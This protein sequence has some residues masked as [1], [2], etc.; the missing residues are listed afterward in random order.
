MSL[1]LNVLFALIFLV[2]G[3]GAA[4][5]FY[6]NRSY[7]IVTREPAGRVEVTFIVVSIS[8]FTHAAIAALVLTLDLQSTL[9]ID[10]YASL[11]AMRQGAIDPEA[12]LGILGYGVAATIAACFLGAAVTP[13]DTLSLSALRI[14]GQDEAEW[15][16]QFEQKVAE[17]DLVYHARLAAAAGTR[18]SVTVLTKQPLGDGLLA[19]Q[20]ELHRYQVGPDGTVEFVS[21]QRGRPFVTGVRP[22]AAFDDRLTASDAEQ[23]IVSLNGRDV[24]AVETRVNADELLK[25]AL[26]RARR[27]WTIRSTARSIRTTLRA[28]TRSAG[29]FLYALLGSFFVF[30]VGG[31]AFF[32][33][34]GIIVWI[35]EMIAIGA[36]FGYASFLVRSRRGDAVS[37]RQAVWKSVLQTL[38][39]LA[40]LVPCGVAVFV[41]S[42]RDADPTLAITGLIVVGALVVGT[43]GTRDRPMDAPRS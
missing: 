40:F 10:P 7:G 30:F 1:P 4:A 23:A 26:E 16:R 39:L 27:P 22:D 9:P 14:V 31:G 36:A 11:A 29:R 3:F 8:L 13:D 34:Y 5:T 35:V 6:R 20:G 41:A 17:E 21:L 19:W 25:L 42:Q 24:L 38:G 43:L 18:P 33:G 2:P 28:F 32:G 12:V 15:R 37:P